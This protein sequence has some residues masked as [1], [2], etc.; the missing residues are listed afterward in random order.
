[1]FL[2]HSLTAIGNRLTAGLPGTPGVR[3]MPG[4]PGTPGVP[5]I[6]CH[7]SKS[8]N[9][10]LLNGILMCHVFSTR[11]LKVMLVKDW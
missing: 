2:F 9:S 4:V 8:F 7:Y 3:V 10:H 11:S 1:M 6:N 5:I